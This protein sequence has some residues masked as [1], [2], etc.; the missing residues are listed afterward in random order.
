MDIFPKKT[1]I[2]LVKCVVVCLGGEAEKLSS[3]STNIDRND[4]ELLATRA[5][6]LLSSSS[7]SSCGLAHPKPKKKSYISHQNQHNKAVKAGWK[8]WRLAIPSPVGRTRPCNV[9]VLKLP[10]NQGCLINILFLH[11]KVEVPSLWVLHHLRFL[12]MWHLVRLEPRGFEWDYGC[13]VL[14]K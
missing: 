4:W 7:S 9:L 10:N 2:R 1:G 5:A 11:A 8:H 12:G 3:V 14:G 13:W 6:S